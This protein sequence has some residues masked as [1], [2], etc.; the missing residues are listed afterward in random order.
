MAING[1]M[2]GD[3][4]MRLIEAR[5]RRAARRA[6][7]P[8]P[9]L[10]TDVLVAEPVSA[11]DNLTPELLR[12][13]QEQGTVRV[14]RPAPIYIDESGN[15]IKTPDE[16][17]RL[18]PLPYIPSLDTGRLQTLEINNQK[19]AEKKIL[20]R[21]GR[22][23]Q[24]QAGVAPAMP[25]P[26]APMAVAPVSSAQKPERM[27]LVAPPQ[28]APGLGSMTPEESQALAEMTL[29]Q[30]RN[31][32]L[33]AVLPFVRASQ[34][35]NQAWT[36]A[37]VD[38]EGLQAAQAT[39]RRPE[40][41]AA[42]RL[43]LAREFAKRRMEG[44]SLE[45]QL[46]QRQQIAQMDAQQAKERLEFEKERNAKALELEQQQLEL[47]RQAEERLG[48]QR[49][50]GG[51]ALTRR[52]RELEIAKLEKELAGLES[53]VKTPEQTLR[54]LQIA[55]LQK[56]LSGE[57]PKK[58]KMAQAS[59]Q[60]MKSYIAELR[61]LYAKHGPE[62]IGPIAARMKQ[63]S[64]AITLEAKNI[65]ELGALSG[66]DKGILERIQGTPTTAYFRDTFGLGDP[67]QSLDFM[68]S[69]VN[70]GLKAAIDI[71]GPAKPEAKSSLEPI[72]LTPKQKALFDTWPKEKKDAFLEE[73]RKQQQG[74]R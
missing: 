60:R 24:A 38:V 22:Q 55:K 47:R 66:P 56:E 18:T 73:Y 29:G 10:P 40:T 9:E 16:P 11:S 42:Q 35:I 41:E 26:Q 21:L 50:E 59:A 49:P 65:G 63:V 39:L 5:E 58:V 13:I 30:S 20:G 34:Q 3:E 4:L 27:P 19:E 7:M 31:A 48:R 68:E 6:A 45:K 74:G 67:M 72:V 54:D 57:D 14:P 37:P 69:W 52:K 36:G 32:R 62:A 17:A 71:Y 44:E 61:D 25:M 51:D 33:E 43:A 1:E 53:G 23:L 2:S 46:A 64:E 12:Q 28:P 70:T 8:A 15:F